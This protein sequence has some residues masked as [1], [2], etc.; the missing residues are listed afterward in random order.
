MG[1]CF[2]CKCQRELVGQSEVTMKNGRKAMRG[3]GG[4][5]QPCDRAF[6]V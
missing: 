6:A 4:G 5:L 3:V 2:K 1:Y